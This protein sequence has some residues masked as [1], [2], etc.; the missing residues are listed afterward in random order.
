ML[1]AYQRHMRRV[2]WDELKLADSDRF[3]GF[4]LDLAVNS[5]DLTRQS[6]SK[7]TVQK[8]KN[9]ASQELVTETSLGS[10]KL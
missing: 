9:T 5:S 3:W 8:K 4:L 2:L 6:L 10:D 7:T 1:S